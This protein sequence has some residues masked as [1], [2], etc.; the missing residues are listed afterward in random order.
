MFLKFALWNQ[1]I[2]QWD[3]LTEISLAYLVNLYYETGLEALEVRRHKLIDD[4]LSVWT[5]EI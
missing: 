2:W 5:K 3:R 4:L 1:I